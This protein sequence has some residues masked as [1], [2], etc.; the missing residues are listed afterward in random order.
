MLELPVHF[1]FILFCMGGKVPLGQGIFSKI[2]V[3]YRKSRKM[4]TYQDLLVITQTY[5][6][7][8]IFSNISSRVNYLNRH[9]R[10]TG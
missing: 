6:K 2:K 10:K 7:K 3:V 5:I 1:C 4:I 9:S 8:S